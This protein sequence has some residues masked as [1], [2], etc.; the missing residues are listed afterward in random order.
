M[1]IIL[2]QPVIV[3]VNFFLWIK[4]NIKI[5]VQQASFF[6]KMFSYNIFW[7]YRNT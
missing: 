2:F 5:N 1:K 4:N 7:F 6:K 3:S